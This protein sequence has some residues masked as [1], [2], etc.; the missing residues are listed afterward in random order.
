MFDRINTIYQTLLSDQSPIQIRD[1]GAGSRKQTNRTLADITNNAA[2]KPWKGRQ[3]YHL[4]KSLKANT[5]LE[6]G[7]NVGIGTAYLASGH[8][9]SRVLT[10]EGDPGLAEIAKRNL[11]Q[12]EIKNVES[13][14]GE[15]SSVLPDLLDNL[16]SPIDLVYLDGNH[17]LDATLQYLEL[18]KPSL[19][20][21]GAIIVDD[22]NWSSGMLSAWESIIDNSWV[23]WSINLGQY[24]IVLWDANAGEAPKHLTYIDYKYKPW[25]IGLFA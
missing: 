1:Y 24:G 20:C 18:I 2:S 22:I 5:I 6:L 14:I 13:H 25:K 17:R 21:K 23:N 4:A 7:T 15:F 12:L 16:Y 10:I 8:Q 9:S 11:N 19:A 3:L